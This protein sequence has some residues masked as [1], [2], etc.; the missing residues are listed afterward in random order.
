MDGSL[1]VR[2]QHRIFDEESEEDDLDDK[3]VASANSS[4]FTAN[5]ADL[6]LC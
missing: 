1:P 3:P 6:F 5:S 4:F 2:M